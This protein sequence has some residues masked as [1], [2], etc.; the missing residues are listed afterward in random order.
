VTSDLD[1]VG[2]ETASNSASQRGRST[3]VPAFKVCPA[4]LSRYPRPGTSSSKV[5][6]IFYQGLVQSQTKW[7]KRSIYLCICQDS[8]NIVV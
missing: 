8:I 1:I 5:H 3:R 4:L 7:Q 6:G 2:E